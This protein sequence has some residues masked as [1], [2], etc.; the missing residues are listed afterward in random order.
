MGGGVRT[1]GSLSGLGCVT[2]PGVYRERSEAGG[3]KSVVTDN[4]RRPSDDCPDSLAPTN[5]VQ[6][7]P[8]SPDVVRCRR[9]SPHLL[10][11]ARSV[12][13]PLVWTICALLEQP[14]VLIDFLY[15]QRLSYTCGLGGII[16]IHVTIVL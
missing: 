14:T 6:G 15:M 5:P 13:R 10:S 16:I 4:I 7:Y 12:H 3:T 11:T 9:F 8:T 1:W 2:L